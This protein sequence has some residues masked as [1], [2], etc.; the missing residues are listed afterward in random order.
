[1][2][3]IED[4]DLNNPLPYIFVS[5]ILSSFF[6]KTYSNDSLL[7]ITIVSSFL[8]LL[9][10][11]KGIFISIIISLFFL[12]GLF[13]N[14]LFY[15]YIPNEAEE[16]RI[17]TIKSYYIKGKIQGRNVY[18]DIEDDELSIGDKILAVGEFKTNLD[19]SKGIIGEYKVDDYKLLKKDFIGY[20]YERRESL[21]KTIESKLGKRKAGFITSVA[22]GYSE[23]LDN[24]DREDM[25]V[26]GI[27]HAISVSGLHMAIVYG[28]LKKI[29]K[30]NISLSIAFLYVIFTG[31]SSSTIRSYI[32][33]FIM[34]FALVVRRN[35][36]PL[37]SISLAGII[38]LI[39][40]P[41]DLF[42]LGFDLSFLATLGIILFNKKLNKKLYKLPKNL[43]EALA[44]SI[45][46]QI[47][48]FP[49][50]IYSFNEFSLNFIIGN[51]I[52]LPVI[53]IIVFLG[54]LLL[55]FN[56]ITP[57]FNYLLY[58][59]Y[60]CIKIID[61]IMDFFW[62]YRINILYFNSTIAFFYSILLIAYYF[63]KKGYKKFIVLPIMTLVYIF[64]LVYNPL[65]NIK[66]YK[67]GALLVSFKGE[68]ILI[69]TKALIDKV[70]LKKITMSDN[71]YRDFNEIK[72]KDKMTIKKEGKNYKLRTGK[73]EYMLVVNKG[74]LDNEYDI[75]DFS[76][77]ELQEVII[78]NDKVISR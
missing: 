31:A 20:L 50:I 36:N 38:L 54:N 3:Y 64:V 56:K 14:S 11:Y 49:I 28:I 68:N 63:Y 61:N 60:C 58:L 8:C 70:K 65:P 48:T 42:S 7:A 73:K 62:N 37:S 55:V 2:K 40:Y 32:M 59:C 10:F 34:S 1:M 41:Y 71:I 66:Y 72:I 5:F 26:F 51:I 33:I 67:E 9:I 27:S 30:S 19:L 25:N 29:F 4:I 23:A 69:Q 39:L 53:N 52:V 47:L 13:N 17:D 76:T 57:I 74:K 15:N 22:F 6:Y 12:V 44:V 46:A 75:I 35:Y 16:I 18:L 24:E 21:Y 43:R 78:F 45:S 77:G